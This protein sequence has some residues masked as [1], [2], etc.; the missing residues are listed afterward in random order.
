[1]SK[2]EKVKLSKW[3]EQINTES[4]SIDL[5]DEF[6]TCLKKMD[7]D[8]DWTRTSDNNIIIGDSSFELKKKKLIRIIN[9]GK[10]DDNN[11]KR[12]F[13]ILY[14]YFKKNTEG[15]KK[16][17]LKNLHL[18]PIKYDK[19]EKVGEITHGFRNIIL[20]YV[21]IKNKK[22]K[23]LAQKKQE[24]IKQE[25]KNKEKEKENKKE[26]KKIK[27]KKKEEGERILKAMMK[28]IDSNS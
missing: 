14:D 20:D 12:I 23:L 22:I 9:T 11:I 15:S 8:F 13:K 5:T 7:T 19:I 18:T 21:T 27:E 4:S 10:I 1:M 3:I 17:F 26:K 25:K 28:Q 6:F 2:N 16:L 24:R